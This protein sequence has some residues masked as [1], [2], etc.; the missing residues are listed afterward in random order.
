VVLLRSI[1]GKKSRTTTPSPVPPSPIPEYLRSPE[2]KRTTTPEYLRNGT[3]LAVRLGLQSIEEVKPPPELDRDINFLVTTRDGVNRELTFEQVRPPISNVHPL[4]AMPASLRR[5]IYGYCFELKEGEE[6]TRTITL[7]P[8]FA[9]KAVFA[10][11]FFASPWDVLDLVWGGLAACRILR[12]DLLAYFWTEYRFHVTLNMFSGPKFSP[13]SHIWLHD[14]L[15][16]VQR[17]TVEVDMTR[18]GGCALPEATR[19]GNNLNKLEYLLCA[20]V[21]GISA[22]A[23]RQRM[24][25]LNILCRRYAGFRPY[26]NI[27]VEEER[28]SHILPYLNQC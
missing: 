25:E 14:Y 7:S 23:G 27:N 13:L 16:I 20:I 2:S 4:F 18:F 19:F 3:P 24:A 5:N 12:H 28:M 21:H 1:S 8:R 11:D 6:E 15:D 10:D 22:R 17:L 9:T 26:D